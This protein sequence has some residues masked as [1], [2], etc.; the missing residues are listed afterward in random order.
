ME[1]ENAIIEH[2][3]IPEEMTYPEIYSSKAIWGFTIF[4][5]SIFGG[6]LLMQNLREYR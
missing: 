3:E 4:F 6:I 1:N 5:S 2:I